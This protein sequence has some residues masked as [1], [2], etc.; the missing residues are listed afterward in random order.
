MIK[1]ICYTNYLF[2]L[3]FTL[4]LIL[5]LISIS[6]INIK[7]KIFIISIIIFYY[8]TNLHFIFFYI[9]VVLKYGYISSVDKRKDNIILY[10]TCYNMFSNKFRLHLNFNKLPQKPSLI[11]CNYC[12]D[13]FENLALI[14]IP[15]NIV[16]L[17]RDVVLKY[18]KLDKLIKWVIVIKKENNYESTKKEIQKHINEG[19]SV[20]S[21]V[22]KDPYFGPTHIRNIRSGIFKI[23]KDLNIPITPLAIDYIDNNYGIINYQNFNMKTGNTFYVN[24][25]KQSMTSVKKFFKN[26]LKSFKKNKYRIIS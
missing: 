9:N 18:T 20:V 25:V 19:R 1:T 17:I 16:I 10:D 13:R 5:I 11:V 21:Y 24:D 2:T 15:R 26:S 12:H 4:L 14:L 23:S 6:D 7:L 22:S 8:Y 3:S